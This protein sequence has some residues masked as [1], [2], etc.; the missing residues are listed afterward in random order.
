MRCY[1]RLSREFQF[2]FFIHRFFY[3]SIFDLCYIKHNPIMFTIIRQISKTK[4]RILF[5]FKSNSKSKHSQIIVCSMLTEK[6]NTEFCYIKR[7]F[8]CNY[9]L[10][11]QTEFLLVPNR[12]KMSKYTPNFV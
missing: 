8:D 9:T 12:S 2:L 7:N 1:R 3:Y 4:H 6:S 5:G 11:Q 10:W